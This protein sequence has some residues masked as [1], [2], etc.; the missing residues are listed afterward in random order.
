MA[1]PFLGLTQSMAL[2]HR[3][4]SL[5]PACRYG[6]R[7]LSCADAHGYVQSTDGAGLMQAI[8]SGGGNS[9]PDWRPDPLRTPLV[10]VVSP[11]GGRA[12]LPPGGRKPKI[13]WFTK[14]IPITA[15][16]PIHMLN[17]ACGAPDCGASTRG[18]S[19]KSAAPAGIRPRSAMG[20]KATGQAPVTSKKTI[21]VVLKGKKKH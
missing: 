15:S 18:T 5:C 12:G 11:S 9:G 8:T 14:R 16:G 7:L 4:A 21:H 20:S 17:V 1:R 2:T 3:R 6:N 19:P 10:P 13:V